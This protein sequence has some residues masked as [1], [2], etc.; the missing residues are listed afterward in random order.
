LQNDYSLKLTS[1]NESSDSP[2]L[3]RTTPPAM[4][5]NQPVSPFG[6]QRAAVEIQAVANMVASNDI[7][8]PASAPPRGQRSRR[9]S[10]D[11]LDDMGAEMLESAQLG[12]SSTSSSLSKSSTSSIKETALDVMHLLSSTLSDRSLALLFLFIVMWGAVLSLDRLTT[13]SYQTIATNS[14]SSHSSLAMINVIRAVVASVAAFPFAVIADLCGRYQAFTIA[15]GFYAS[16]HIVMAASTTVSSYVGGII[17]YEIGA[18]ALVCLQYTVLADV[19][20]SR[21]RLFFQMLPQMP[22]LIFSF[23]SSDIYSAILPRWRWGIGMFAIL[24]PVSIFPVVAILHSSHKGQKGPAVTSTQSLRRA[25]FQQTTTSPMRIFVLFKHVWKLADVFGL[26]LLAASLSL[27]LVPL[28]LAASSPGQWENANILGIISCGIVLAF[29]FIFWETRQAS[30]PILAR[31]LL[32]NW[33]FWGGGA[34]LCLLWTAHALMIAFFPTYLYVVYNTSNRAQQNLSV[35]YSFTIAASSLPVA[36]MVRYSRRYK[37]FAL[38]GVV[39]F[40]AGLGLMISLRPSSSI[41]HVVASQV[42][43]G[44]GGAMTIAPIMAAVQVSV[45]HALVAHS[46]AAINV[47]PCL[48]NAIGAAVA[49]ALW[50]NTL[51]GNLIKDLASSGHQN[52]VHNIY[53]EPLTWIESYPLGTSAR[54]GV[55][56][57]YS[58]VWRLLMV[59]ATLVCAA[60]AL[61]TMCMKNIVL[62][63]FLSTAE[64]MDK[65]SGNLGDETSGVSKQRLFGDRMF[66]KVEDALW[67]VFSRFGSSKTT[68]RTSDAVSG[69]AIPDGNSAYQSRWGFLTSRKAKP[70]SSGL[71][72]G[73]DVKVG[74]EKEDMAFSPADVMPPFG[75]A[76]I[77]VIDRADDDEADGGIPH[78]APA[79]PSNL[80]R[81]P[82]P[83][84]LRR[85]GE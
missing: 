70:S 67:R 45:P 80:F 63:D 66:E 13:Y 29:L 60:S 68:R 75:L 8:R 65:R 36:L 83:S 19:T 12:T 16:G 9:T 38:I 42:I 26:L 55:I 4:S 24:G 21:N 84:P 2:V 17:L 73:L 32:R 59:T 41:F 27:I 48:G 22:F 7:Q 31:M 47:F 71:G 79:G 30:H 43:I 77:L 46:I 53:S 56:E 10:K 33:T 37:I 51:P 20:S 64:E 40:T 74:K 5:A 1:L 85:S 57:A 54:T 78:S 6:K 61:S 39:F 81:P 50:S 35:I 3:H 23:V 49:G 82:H 14:F 69:I 34:S 15:L 58:T 72:C 28:T 44:L 76:P 11:V 52:E 25:S 18:N 62:N